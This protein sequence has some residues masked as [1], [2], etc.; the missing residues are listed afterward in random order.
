LALGLG[1]H[2]C[3]GAALARMELRIGLQE[4]LARFPSYELI[5]ERWERLVSDTGRGF[6]RQPARL[7]AN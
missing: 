5:P 6:V 2:F 7:N 4:L 1:V 3:L